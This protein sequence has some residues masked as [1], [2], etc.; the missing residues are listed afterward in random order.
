STP[1]TFGM[2]FGLL[3]WASQQPASIG[4]SLMIMVGIGMAFPYF[5]L[6]AFPELA[7]KMPRTGPWAELVKQ[8]MGFLLILSA[9]YFARRFIEQALGDKVFWWTLFAVVLAAGIFLVARSIKFSKTR[10]GPAVA[11]VIAILFVAPSLLIT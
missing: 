11:C 1:W 8:M 5:V 10:I 4:L 3:I 6:S 9:I 7:R 2:F